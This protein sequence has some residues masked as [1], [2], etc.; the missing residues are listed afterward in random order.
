MPLP[1]LIERLSALPAFT[2]LLN[3]LPA[4]RGILQASGLAGS[5]D[6]VLMA[7]LA[8]QQPNRMIAIVADQLPEA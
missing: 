3:S 2:Q 6:A 8:E 4:T 7:A 1:S 5:S